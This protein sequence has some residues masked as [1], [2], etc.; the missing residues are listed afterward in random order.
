MR[1]DIEG[2]ALVAQQLMEQY[3]HMTQSEIEAYLDNPDAS[4]SLLNFADY[5]PWMEVKGDNRF[6]NHD[7]NGNFQKTTYEEYEAN[8]T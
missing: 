4:M 3:P 5:D 7:D 1:D 8:R 2:L 6:L